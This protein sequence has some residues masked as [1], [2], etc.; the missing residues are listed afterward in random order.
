M[1]AEWAA[2][3]LEE[4][5]ADDGPRVMAD[6][7]GKQ[8]GLAAMEWVQ[9]LPEGPQRESATRAA[10]VSWMK[11][12]EPAAEAWLLAQ[13][14]SPFHDPALNYYARE[15]AKTNS[16]RSLALCEKI[17]DEK[18]RMGCLK[19]AAKNWYRVDSVAAEGWLQE[20]P[21]DEE[22][23]SQVRRADQRSEVEEGAGKERA[24][25]PGGRPAR[26]R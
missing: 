5:W 13:E 8:D 17:Q 24:K 10:F 25:R 18:R 6:Q 20:S 12:D 21:L 3:Y 15:L 7:W 9:A 22:S 14:L 23:R 4:E 1:S 26:R 19:K 16:V 11:N 2:P